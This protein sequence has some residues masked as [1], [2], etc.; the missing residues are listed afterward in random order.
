[1]MKKIQGLKKVGLK[2]WLVM[3]GVILGLWGSWAEAGEMV[4]TENLIKNPGAENDTTS[5]TTSNFTAWASHEHDNWPKITPRSGA[6]FFASN[7]SNVTCSM[8]QD[9][10]VKK[11]AT[12]TKDGIVT[13]TFK[14]YIASP[15]DRDWGL[16]EVV[17]H[18]EG[19]GT[20]SSGA[21][22]YKDGNWH[23]HT[24][25]KNVTLPKG[26]EFIRVW[27][28]ASNTGTSEFVNSYFDD[29]E[30]TLTYPKPPASEL[31]IT[32][33]KDGFNF[34]NLYVQTNKNSSTGEYNK[35]QK[36]TLKFKN[37][38]TADMNW[39]IVVDYAPWDRVSK[40]SGNLPVG[41]IDTVDVWIEPNVGADG[42]Q[43]NRWITLK[44]T[45]DSEIKLSETVKT[46]LPINPPTFAWPGKGSNDRVNVAV[47]ESV[48]FYVNKPNDPT[49]PGATFGGYLWKKVTGPLS[50]SELYELKTSGFDATTDSKKSYMFS[51]TGNYTIYC[52]AYENNG[53]KKIRSEVIEIPVS[54]WKRPTVND[55]PPATSTA[56]TTYWRD[57]RYVGFK[58]EYVSFEANGST[59]NNDWNEKIEKYIWDFDNNW[60]TDD[61][62]NLV[63]HSFST[64][65]LNGKVRCKAVTNYGIQSE[66]KMFDLKIYNSL[67]VDTNGPY[68]GRPNKDVEL[69]SSVN[70]IDYPG[71]KFEYKWDGSLAD[72][73]GKLKYKQLSVG[74]YSVSAYV[75]VITAEGLVRESYSN[76]TVTID[77]GKPTAMPGGPYRGGIYGGNYTPIQFLGNNPDFVEEEDIGKIKE[78][79]WSFKD[80]KEAITGSATV[81]NPTYKYDKAGKY[82]VELMVKSEYGKW[83]DPKKTTVQVI[84][85]KIEGVVRAADLRTPVRDVRVTLD[86]S[87]VDK[88]VLQKIAIEQAI[89]TSGVGAFWKLTDNK[90]YYVFEHLPLGNYRISVSKKDGD[91]WHEFETYLK[92]TELTLDQP[93]Q[94]GIDFVDKTVF[95]VGGRVI[96]S[97]Q[98]NGQDV[99]VDG[100][101]VKVYSVGNTSAL[102]SELTTKSLSAT[103]V[104]Y[105]IPLLAGKYLFIGEKSGHDIR[106]KKNTP[107]YDPDLQLVTIKD[108]RTDIDFIVNIR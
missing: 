29:M 89:N 61:G 51:E 41:A 86:S 50:N 87:H 26:T 2:H 95:P 93:D 108:A 104:N 34:G 73:N 107:G 19:K 33:G 80:I 76:T 40:M 16:I 53:D 100:V 69:Q 90:G 6:R 39:E 25:A 24:P 71:A 11:Y 37:S 1:M 92:N 54:V 8:Y 78:W 81:W 106:I 31:E 28:K 59:Q 10:D 103:G 4:T 62:A 38:G 36:K 84:D 32:E 79:Q 102:E 83:S 74:N 17:A 60:S 97:I 45:V 66:E 96:Y 67:S 48:T 68:T 58:G 3:L 88:D 70:K 85:G 77:C 63:S 47:N 43:H 52:A 22:Y 30:L 23:E 21:Q 105:S 7:G 65:N 44:P 56:F 99:L 82:N 15:D 27:M 18:P 91:N 64:P 57:K 35:E 72:S 49:F 42:Q 98:K 101:K 75:K 94:L 12:A 55:T 9:I 20:W 46:Y 5:W 13:M 14:G